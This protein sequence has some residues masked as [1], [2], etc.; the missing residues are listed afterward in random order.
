MKGTRDPA[1]HEVATMLDAAVAYRLAE[2]LNDELIP[3]EVISDS[4]L[5]WSVMVPS[6]VVERA[7]GIIADAELSEAE[8]SYLARGELGGGMGSR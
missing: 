6:D 7:R 8:L 4:A 2:L 1:R 5:R 3:A